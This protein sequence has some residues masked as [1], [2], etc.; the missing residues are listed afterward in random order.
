M[1]F[2]VGQPA[3]ERIHQ[4]TKVVK[5]PALIKAADERVKNENTDEK[6]E[7]ILTKKPETAQRTEISR[8]NSQS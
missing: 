2:L 6:Q 7:P 5:F 1:E 4:K 8:Q 3:Q